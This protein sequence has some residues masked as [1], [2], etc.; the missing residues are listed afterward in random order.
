MQEIQTN[1][2]LG[3][4]VF[5]NGKPNL[6]LMPKETLDAL[7]SSLLALMLSDLGNGE[8]DA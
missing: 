4:K 6:A 3:L 8:G 1:N 5:I 7:C 2:K